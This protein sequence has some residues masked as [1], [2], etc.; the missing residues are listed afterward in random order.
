MAYERALEADG[1]W[2]DLR[3]SERRMSAARRLPPIPSIS[4]GTRHG[5]SYRQR[6]QCPSQRRGSVVIMIVAVLCK[7][8][9]RSKRSPARPDTAIASGCAVASFAPSHLR[10]NAAKPAQRF[11]PACRYLSPS[12]RGWSFGAGGACNSPPLEHDPEIWKPV[13]PRLEQI[14]LRE[15]RTYPG[16]RGRFRRR[17]LSRH[18]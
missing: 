12:I 8:V 17:Y 15:I 6:H 10:T 11:A 18:R 16:M 2:S 1:C 3:S 5:K 13:F 7:A 9:C 14:A 4:S